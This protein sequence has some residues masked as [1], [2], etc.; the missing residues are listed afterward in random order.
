LLLPAVV[1]GATT[2]HHGIMSLAPC[3]VVTAQPLEHAQRSAL[4]KAGWAAAK[5]RPD[6]DYPP[7]TRTVNLPPPD[8]N[9]LSL[10][11]KNEIRMCRR[12]VDEKLMFPTFSGHFRHLGSLSFMNHS[13]FKGN[14][15]IAITGT[16]MTKPFNHQ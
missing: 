13:N 12:L 15:P 7:S 5:G 10:C 9:R 16:L 1:V 8:F 2:K 4:D 11:Q 3:A 14:I 6:D